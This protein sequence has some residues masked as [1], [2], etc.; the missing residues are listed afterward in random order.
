MARAVGENEALVKAGNVEALVNK[1]MDDN[2]YKTLMAGLSPPSIEQQLS[3]ILTILRDTHNIP[4]TNAQTITITNKTYI[5]GIGTEGKITVYPQISGG[6]GEADSRCVTGDTLLPIVQNRSENSE[7]SDSQKVRDSE[8]Q[9]V[10]SS[11]YSEFSEISY[12][13]IKDIKG[14]EYVLSLNEQTGAI[15][16]RQI[17]GLLPQGKKPVYELVTEDGRTIRTTGNHP[18]LKK[19]DKGQ[20]TMDKEWTQVSDL[21]SGDEVAVVNEDSPQYQSSLR[22]TVQ[23]FASDNQELS[24]ADIRGGSLF[25]FGTQSG[26]GNDSDSQQNQSSNKIEGFQ[27]VKI[28]DFVPFNRNKLID[29]QP[30]IPITPN[31]ITNAFILSTPA[32]NGVIADA[33]TTNPKLAVNSDNLSS[34]ESFSRNSINSNIVGENSAV[35]F[36]KI[37]SITPAGEEEVFDIEVEGTHNF[38]GGHWV[39]KIQDSSENSENS[40]SQKVRDSESQSVRPS[41]SSEYFFGGIVAHN[42]QIEPTQT[43]PN[44]QSIEQTPSQPS[45]NSLLDRAGEMW[46]KVFQF[47]NSIGGAFMQWNIIPLIQTPLSLAQQGIG[48]AMGVVGNFFGKELSLFGFANKQLIINNSLIDQALQVDMVVEEL[49]NLKTAK[50]IDVLDI[51]NRA[52]VFEPGVILPKGIDISDPKNVVNHFSSLLTPKFV[53]NVDV[54]IKNLESGGITGEDLIEVMLSVFSNDGSLTPEFAQEVIETNTDLDASN[55][56]YLDSIVNQAL[57]DNVPLRYASFQY[58]LP[59]YQ[60]WLNS[61]NA[62]ESDLSWYVDLLRARKNGGKIKLYKGIRNFDGKDILPGGLTESTN[63]SASGD[64]YFE[65]TGKANTDMETM[66]RHVLLANPSSSG[67]S[68]W[69]PSKW[70][71]EDYIKWSGGSVIEFEID[72]ND[73]RVR[74]MAMIFKNNS[75]YHFRW[76]PKQ[77]TELQSARE[78]LTRIDG[79]RSITMNRNLDVII[80]GTNEFLIEGIVK[81]GEYKVI[82]GSINQEEEKP[83][84]MLTPILRKPASTDISMPSL[85]GRIF[86]DYQSVAGFT[87]R[88]DEPSAGGIES[89]LGVKSRYLTMHT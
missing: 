17:V 11:E 42:T 31:P 20:W 74:D 87:D 34:W 71:A 58:I 10:R 28:H 7:N 8:S 85:G 76:E 89:L 55:K 40:D 21:R 49:E 3:S 77:G 32:N 80:N 50:G 2:N 83:L 59:K 67:F 43:N 86:A 84:N 6:S 36:S 69:T 66:L 19:M 26:I 60:S 65:G 15:E 24:R 53:Q 81:N 41:E 39:R 68:S 29:T 4:L 46:M 82:E 1:I 38:I 45:S 30:N 22:G 51:M 35:K 47:Y 78:A 62:R 56:Q 57:I 18:Y 9:N 64:Q 48:W 52:R 27:P 37:I 72:I 23:G 25:G 5:I 54:F 33:N 63:I 44:Q 13:P 14:G 79:T 73:P 88:V 75:E 61:I 12:V 70:I 16:P